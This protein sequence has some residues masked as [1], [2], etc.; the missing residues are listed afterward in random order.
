[1]QNLSRA[2]NFANFKSARPTAKF[3]KQLER[4]FSNDSTQT[5]ISEF[6]PSTSK[7][8]KKFIPQQ[9]AELNSIIFNEATCGKNE[10]FNSTALLQLLIEQTNSGTEK[11]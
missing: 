11:S 1:L 2:V 8:E 10:N 9:A 4:I 5:K 3:R 7:N 6:F